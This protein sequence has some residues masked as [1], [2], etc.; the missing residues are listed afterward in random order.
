MHGLNGALTM[1]FD[2]FVHTRHINA[3]TS[4]LAL[5]KANYNV[6]LVTSTRKQNA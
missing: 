2:Y 1:D 6:S 3:D 5:S 4:I